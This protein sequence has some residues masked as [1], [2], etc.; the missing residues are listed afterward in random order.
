MYNYVLIKDRKTHL[1]KF[2]PSENKELILML[3]GL[4]RSYKGWLGAEEELSEK[5]DILCIDLPG[6]GL[7]KDEKYLYRIEDMSEKV[8]EVLKSL[9]I[10]KLFIVA[11]SLGSLVTYELV[12]VLGKEIIQGIVIVVPS[13]SGIG[14]KRISPLAAKTLGSSSFVSKEVKLA[15]LQNMLIGKAEDGSDVF[16][17]DAQWERRWK[18]QITS[19]MNDLG[20][21]GQF[22]QL[23]SAGRYFAKDGLDYIKNNQIPLKVIV[24]GDDKMIPLE[25][26]IQVYEYMKHPKSELIELKNAGHDFIVTHKE[27]LKEIVSKFILEKNYIVKEA[28]VIKPK[29][30]KNKD[31]NGILFFLTTLVAGIL[32]LIAVKNNKNKK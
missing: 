21:K 28:N 29:R 17:N 10:T 6:V 12:K 20:R 30:V 9:N 18:S 31:R 27:Q 25:H 16:Q 22:A 14:L 4:A 11:P 2:E 24:S 19:D 8:V 5:F 23:F 13:H 3:R 7:S 15:M 32:L 26:E 1:N